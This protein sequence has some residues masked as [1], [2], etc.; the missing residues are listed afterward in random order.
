MS[1][2]AQPVTII[3]AGIAGLATA[4]AMAQRGANVTL[5]EQAT[6]IAEVG[7]GLQISPN[8]AI[9]LQAL[10]LGGD[11]ED[12]SIRGQAVELRDGPTG[13]LVTRLDIRQ[14]HPRQ[15]WHFLHR[16]D[17]IG[18]LLK[19]ARKRGVR[20]GLSDKVARVSI[21][22]CQPILTLANG[23]QIG[24]D[25]VIGADG[26]HSICRAAVDGGTSP[27]FTHQVAWRALIPCQRTE[28]AVAEIHMGEGRHLV[29]YPLRGGTIR[30]LVAIEERPDWAEEGWSHRDKPENLRLAFASFGPRAQEWL[31]RVDE[32]YLWG[33][34]RHKVARIWQAALAEGAVA[35]VGDAAHPTLPFMAQGANMALEDAWALAACLD[36][37]P[38]RATSLRRYQALRRSRAERIVEAANR[39]ARNYHLGGIRRSLAHQALRIGGRLAPGLALGR[40]DWI[41]GYDVVQAASRI[42]TGT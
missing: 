12:A 17:L 26:L 27:F 13:R 31:S 25:L 2:E 38:D 15:G 3:G 28:S 32:V 34:F 10:G 1:L 16:A 14:L 37:G 30:N 19:A 7:A 11:L 20:F 4:C 40:L 36:E 18:L 29:S 35:L 24:S 39:N 23:S 22:E 41:H 42:Q 21:D 6:E 9:V 5:L 8:G 33:L